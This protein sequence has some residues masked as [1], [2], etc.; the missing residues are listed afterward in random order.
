VRY[1]LALLA[2]SYAGTS[3]NVWIL[4]G[5]LPE[6]LLPDFSFLAIAYAGLFVPGPAGFT[7]ALLAAFFREVT[8]VGPPWSFFLASLA[9]Y[10]F[11]RE[12][13]LHIFLRTEGLVL[14]VV[15]ALL[16]AESLSVGLLLHLTGAHPFSLLWGAQEA[17]R[18]AWT[19]LLAVPIF[20]RLASRRQRVKE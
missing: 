20:T 16:L 14:A 6:Y 8:V 10:F 5:L 13:S 3:A 15:A 18:I 12:I 2:L 9:L 19:S 4:A 7:A 17:V 11:T 1:F